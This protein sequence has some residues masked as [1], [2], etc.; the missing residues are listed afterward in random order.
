MTD[1][2]QRMTEAEREQRWKNQRPRDASTVILLDR[3]ESEPRVLLGRRHDRHVFLPGKYVFPGGRVDRGDGRVRAAAELDPRVQARLV[4]RMKQGQSLH[5]ARALA[6]AAVREVFEETGIAIGRPVPGIRSR[7]RDWGAFY[8]LGLA[9][10]LSGLRFIAR[11]IT[12]PRRPRRF[13]TR[14]FALDLTGT[15]SRP[16]R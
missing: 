12:P 1:Y 13:D 11:A 8:N 7:A 6:L 15:A 9:P 2:A 4:N 3:R 10:D 14:F 16:R 5:R